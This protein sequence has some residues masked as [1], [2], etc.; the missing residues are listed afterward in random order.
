M[1]RC[2][3]YVFIFLLS[4][5]KHDINSGPKHKKATIIDAGVDMHEDCGWMIRMED[6]SLYHPSALPPLAKNHN[7]DVW[8]DY[9]NTT[10]SFYCGNGHT[11]YPIIEI[12]GVML[13]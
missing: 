2:L 11:A 10:D 6:S 9:F 3:I 4:C 8:V 12:I 1:K 13:R 7:L 5:E